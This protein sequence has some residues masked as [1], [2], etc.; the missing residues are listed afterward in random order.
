MKP[1]ASAL[2]ELKRVLVEISFITWFLDSLVVFTVSN[3]VFLLIAV[4]WGYAF[5][6]TG[7]YALFHG[8]TVFRKIKY[9]HVEEKVPELQEQLKEMR[10]QQVDNLV[11]VQTI[12]QKA[13]ELK[14]VPAQEE[15]DKKIA[16]KRKDYIDN[17]FKSEEEMNKRI[18]ELGLDE[19]G[20]NKML[21]EE[22]ILEIAQDYMLKDVKVSDED[23]SKYYEEK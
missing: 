2:N 14:L 13:E 6:P 19:A 21:K 18:E 12:L 15:L 8:F 7:I 9:K 10:K 17:V 1:I 23:I 16:E 4:P 20:F 22:V 11:T 5:V 3:L